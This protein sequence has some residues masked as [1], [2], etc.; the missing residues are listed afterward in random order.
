MTEVSP[1]SPTIH[2]WMDTFMHRSMR[3]WARFIKAS[4][5]SMPQF[6]ILMQLYHKG[7]CGMSEISEGFGITPAAASQ[8]VDKLV[9][10][11]LIARTEDPNDR[12]AKQI[13][14]TLQGKQL[15]EQGIAERYRWLER[16]DTDLNDTEK[17][18]VSEALEILIRAVEPLETPSTHE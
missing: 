11:D 8:L 1:F 6:S 5:L 17:E 18:K 12:R 2:K 13:A 14:L 7:P 9:Q 10:S 3:G 16:L 15:I 4:G